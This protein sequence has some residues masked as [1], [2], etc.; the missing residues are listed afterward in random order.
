MISAAI[1]LGDFAASS[2]AVWQL[3]WQINSLMDYISKFPEHSMY[4]EKFK[5]F[6]E[7][8]PKIIDGNTPVS[9][10]RELSLKNVS[11]SYE[12]NSEMSLKNISMNIKKGE[13]IALVGYNGAGKSTLIKLIMRLYDPAEG[14]VEMNG[15]NI[16][17]YTIKGYRDKIG[18]VFQDYQIFA[19]TVA[20]NVLTD[21]YTDEK[22]ETILSALKF[23]SFTDKLESLPLGLQTPLTREFDKSGVNLSG[24]EAQRVSLAR[25]LANQPEVLLLDEPTAALNEELRVQ[26]E[27]A[28]NSAA[29]ARALTCILVTHDA[30]QAARFASRV[31]LMQAGRLV[32][33]GTPAE[34]LN[35][36]PMA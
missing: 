35:V 33:V 4:V 3:Y 34:V 27:A 24:G 2:N 1:T 9:E 31:A 30:A 16:K 6:L 10:F 17:T 8:E 15:I 13:K 36:E 25:A 28:I 23:S 26:V 19:M 21:S 32:K 11:F 12:G 18:A 29:H 22:K 5:T 14:S 20:E 7:Y